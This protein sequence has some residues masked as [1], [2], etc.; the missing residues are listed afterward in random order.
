MAPPAKAEGCLGTV[1]EENV[2]N[3][4]RIPRRIS[5]NGAV[6]ARS[7]DCRGIPSCSLHFVRRARVREHYQGTDGAALVLRKVRTFEEYL[8]YSPRSSV[9]DSRHAVEVSLHTA[10]AE[11]SP[12]VVTSDNSPGSVS[13]EGS[14]CVVVEDSVDD[15]VVEVSVE[16]VSGEAVAVAVFPVGCAD[17]YSLGAVVGEHTQGADVE[18]LCGAVTFEEPL[19]ED[20][21]VAPAE[22]SIHALGEVSLDAAVVG[23]SLVVA[24]GDN[25]LEAVSFEGHQHVVVEESMEVSPQVVV[26]EDFRVAVVAE[27]SQGAATEASRGADTVEESFGED[28]LDAH[29]EEF[30]VAVSEVSLGTVVVGNSLLAA[31]GGN[32]L[33]AVSVEG[34]SF[35][36]VEDFGDNV[37]YSVVK[38]SS[39]VDKD[40]R[41]SSY[42][43]VVRKVSSKGQFSLG[44]VAPPPSEPS[45]DNILG[46]EMHQLITRNGSLGRR[47]TN[48]KV[49]VLPPFK[50]S[51]QQCSLSD[52]NW[53]TVT[54]KGF[55][56][57]P[58]SEA[59]ERGWEDLSFEVNSV[60]FPSK[61][62]NDVDV[63]SLNKSLS[64][65]N[66]FVNKCAKMVRLVDD[67][68]DE[69][70]K[71][72]PS[73]AVQVWMNENGSQVSQGRSTRASTKSA[74]S[75]SSQTEVPSPSQ[76]SVSV[77]KDGEQV[78]EGE[79]LGQDMHFSSPSQLSQSASC[80][81]I[82]IRLVQRC[83]R[84]WQNKNSRV[85]QSEV[86]NR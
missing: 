82:V 35:V 6:K 45:S 25:S 60:Q 58:M 51:G 65:K 83:S 46:E 40:T 63:I 20:S 29:G 3:R 33:A 31:T 4:T 84:I 66:G 2:V 23:N 38:V 22:D 11:N 10:V 32:S 71:R 67:V 72:K 7:Q 42:A 70:C 53:K 62:N 18:A 79:G 28:S 86:E 52:T 37:D 50:V 12:V 48:P 76:K 36:V 26:V 24:T 34:S 15:T 54:S 30:P 49:V 78:Q 41:L 85:K 80:Y 19:G 61:N 9:E 47:F 55:I 74:G 73:D 39:D 75:V 59:I 5:S 8:A 68:Y 81:R 14:H 69:V 21:L 56:P 1:Q 27:D 44:R 13:S 17:E 57:V 64:V 16:K 77:Q 43:D